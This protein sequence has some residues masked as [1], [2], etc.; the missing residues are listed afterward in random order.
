MMEVV[1]K[2]KILGVSGSPVKR[3]NTEAFL[4]ESLKAA[5]EIENVN[6][7][8]VSLAGRNIQDCEHRLFDFCRL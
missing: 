2:I 5:G 3:G 7:E 4:E 1:M 6:T 8:L